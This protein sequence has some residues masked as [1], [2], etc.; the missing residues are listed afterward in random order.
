MVTYKVINC[1]ND[2]VFKEVFSNLNIVSNLLSSIFQT[3][4]DL[5]HIKRGKE[6]SAIGV[7]YKKSIFDLAFILD[8][9]DNKLMINLEMQNR[10]PKYYKLMNRLSYYNAKQLLLGC[11]RGDEYDTVKSISIC[12]INYDI[13]EIEECVSIL[14][15]RKGKIKVENQQIILIQLTKVDKCDN[16]ELKKWIQLMTAKDLTEFLNSDNKYIKEA[17]M[18]I[19][20]LNE[21]EAKKFALLSQE[22]HETDR[23]IEMNGARKEGLEK[24]LKEGLKEGERNKAISFAL[25]LLNKNYNIKEISELTELSIEEIENLKKSS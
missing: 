23:K 6:E 9:F 7:N 17:S 16:M 14:E 2:L 18:I 19:R 3:N 24:G 13:K 25:K 10:R 8:N 5:E 1:T 15:C 20:Y 12:F 22:K 21:D 11:I 4:V